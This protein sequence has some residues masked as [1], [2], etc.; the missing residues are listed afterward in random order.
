MRCVG[1]LNWGLHSRDGKKWTYVINFIGRMGAE[2][3][4]DVRMTPEFLTRVNEDELPLS[5]TQDFI[6]ELGVG[7]RI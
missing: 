2:E 7:V 3:G 4:E 5:K 1:N 6:R